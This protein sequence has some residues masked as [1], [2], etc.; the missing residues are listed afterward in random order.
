MLS[1]DVNQVVGSGVN[2]KGWVASFVSPPCF[3]RSLGC[4]RPLIVT[5][6][7]ARVNTL[8]RIT[9]SLETLAAASF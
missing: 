8:G 1:R 4:L 3:W 5:A 6:M 7:S 2:F 9:E